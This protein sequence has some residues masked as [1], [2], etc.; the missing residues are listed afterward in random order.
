MRSRS[1]DRIID[2]QGRYPGGPSPAPAGRLR[3]GAGERLGVGCRGLCFGGRVGSLMPPSTLS[4]ASV[5]SLHSVRLWPSL[6]TGG[7]A[8]HCALGS[9]TASRRRWCTG[10]SPPGPERRAAPRVA[11]KGRPPEPLP[12]ERRG[13]AR[14]SGMTVQCGMVVRN[15]S[16]SSPFESSARQKSESPQ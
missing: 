4:K 16:G 10:G 11:G 9:A 15:D 5:P 14:N 6:L 13:G 3:G 7:R 8:R 12:C 1:P 2:A